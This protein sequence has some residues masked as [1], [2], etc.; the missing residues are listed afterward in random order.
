MPKLLQKA[1]KAYENQ[2]IFLALLDK[3]IMLQENLETWE[4]SDLKKSITASCWEGFSKQ[5]E[6]DDRPPAVWWNK[7]RNQIHSLSSVDDKDLFLASL[8]YGQPTI[9]KTCYVDKSGD[10]EMEPNSSADV[11]EYPAGIQVTKHNDE[12]DDIH[13]ISSHSHNDLNI[14]TCEK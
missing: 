4:L 10:E 9:L 13:D 1:L 11:M 6:S 3:A 8:W 5:L 7:Y 14:K 12:D 2:L